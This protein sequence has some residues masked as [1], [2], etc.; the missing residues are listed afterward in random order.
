M[1]VEG[2]RELHMYKHLTDGTSC[3]SQAGIAKD[4]VLP[5]GLAALFCPPQDSE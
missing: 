2:D 1:K 5:L 4:K 3:E